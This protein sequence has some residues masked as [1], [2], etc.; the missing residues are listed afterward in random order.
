MSWKYLNHFLSNDTPGYGGN[1]DFVEE[2]TKDMNSGSSCNQVKLTLTNHVGTH[3][4]APRH[5]SKNGKTL[6]QMPA[7]FWVFDHVQFM[8]LGPLERGTLINQGH[9]PEDINI[10]CELLLLKSHFEDLRDHE[11]Y[12]KKNPG[13]DPEFPL[14]LR[15]RFPKLRAIGFDFISV[16][17]FM[18]RDAGKIAHI[19]LLSPEKSGNPLIAIEDMALNGILKSP[20][21]VIIAPMP[22][23]GGD[24]A[25]ALVLAKESL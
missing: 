2:R 13:L 9:L 25:P 17:S 11:D 14:Y 15:D 6:D 23:K 8:D 5:F 12:W 1:A 10:E 3:I 21:Q 4:D 7:E 22:L 18:H 16:T 24:G 20:E 19:N